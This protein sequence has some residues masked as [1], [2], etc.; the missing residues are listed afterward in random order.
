MQQQQARQ[1]GL[2]H[3]SFGAAVYFI[4][5][6]FVFANDVVCATNFFH[7]SIHVYCVCIAECIEGYTVLQWGVMLIEMLFDIPSSGLHTLQARSGFPNLNVTYQT[8]LYH[9]MEVCFYSAE[10]FVLLQKICFY[11]I[12]KCYSFEYFV[13]HQ[14]YYTVL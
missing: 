4:Y 3:H 5:A 2:S 8:E 11:P 13:A 14:H 9:L 6:G 12:L 1:N 7:P 10:Y